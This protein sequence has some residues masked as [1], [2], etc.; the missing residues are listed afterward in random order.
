MEYRF[1]ELCNISNKNNNTSVS[2]MIKSLI[3]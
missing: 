3:N 2:E 1:V